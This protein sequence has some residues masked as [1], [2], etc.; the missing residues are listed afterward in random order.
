MET[1]TFRAFFFLFLLSA[2]KFAYHVWLKT[3]DQ[4]YFFRCWRHLIKL[5]TFPWRY[6]KGQAISGCL[7]SRAYSFIYLFIYLFISVNRYKELS[8]KNVCCS[9]HLLWEPK[10]FRTENCICVIQII[11][12]MLN[13]FTVGFG[14]FNWSFSKWHTKSCQKF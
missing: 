10:T 12:N 2:I 14:I 3:P 5:S 4:A 6:K 8:R 11:C 7:D 13:F 9:W 1:W